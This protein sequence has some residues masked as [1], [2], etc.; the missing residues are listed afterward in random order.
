MKGERTPQSAVFSRSSRR[1]SFLC[2]SLCQAGVA[3]QMAVTRGQGAGVLGEENQG[4]QRQMNRLPSLLKISHNK[5]VYSWEKISGEIKFTD[6]SS[7]GKNFSQEILE[8]KESICNA[9]KGETSEKLLP[10]M[11]KPT[12]FFSQAIITSSLPAPQSHHFRDIFG[13]YT[14]P[15]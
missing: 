9:K 6:K 7:W 14:G 8:K 3:E 4:P 5:G 10:L 2:A 12:A 11:M 15:E 1:T 13:D